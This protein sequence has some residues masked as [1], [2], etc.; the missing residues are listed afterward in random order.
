MKKRLLIGADGSKLDL[1]KA[2]DI[3]GTATQVG[4]IALTTIAQIQDKKKRRQFEQALAFLSNDQ[5]KVMERQLSTAKSD[6]DRIKILSDVL[7]QIQVERIKQVYNSPIMEEK[8]KQFKT[9]L[10]ISG[11]LIIGGGL[12]YLIYKKA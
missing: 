11:V 1:S 4:S 10:F 8:Q 3:L 6:V 5:E 2:S 12:A 9:I 7:T